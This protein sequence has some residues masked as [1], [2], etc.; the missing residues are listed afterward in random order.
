M[1]PQV[2]PP[3]TEQQN[4]AS[5]LNATL[6][7]GVSI[8]SKIWMPY[9]D[10]I[11]QVESTQFRVNRDVLAKHSSVFRDLFSVPQPA[12]EPTTDGCHTV[13]LFDRAD[14]WA[15]LLAVLYEPFQHQSRPQFNTLAAMLRLGK[16]YDFKQPQQDAVS[17]IRYEFPSDFKAFNDLD[18]DMTKIKYRRGIY[19]DLLNLAYECGI[20]SSVPL[21][22]FCCLRENTLETLFDGVERDDG[23]RA[24]FSDELK[25]NMALAFGKMALFQHRT[26]A[27][28]RDDSVVPHRSCTSAIRCTQ[29]RNEMARVVDQDHEGQFNLG[30]TIDQWDER[31]MG[32]L[33][34]LCEEAAIAVYD[35]NRAKGWELLPTFFGLAGWKDLKDDVD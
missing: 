11:L 16:K 4:R 3:A 29:Q 34:P 19:C 12:N 26:L 25:I 24:T 1:S 22:A 14:D 8:R 13:E 17:R 2:S 10:L 20:Y 31:W 5:S 33:C 28:L 32:K 15:E 21:L 35:L 7:G 23:S 30:Y 27:W 6:E 9:G 18:A